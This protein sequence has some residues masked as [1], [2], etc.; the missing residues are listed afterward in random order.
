MPPLILHHVPDEELYTGDDGL[1]RPYAMLFGGGNDGNNSSVRSRRLVPETGS[2]GKSTRRSRS[3]T[4]TPAAKKEDPT[5]AAAD[6]IFTQFLA[7]KSCENSDSTQ[8][9]SNLNSV[10]QLNLSSAS[11][12]QGDGSTVISRSKKHRDKEPTEVILRGFKS[13][14]QYAAIREYERIAGRICEDYPRDPPVDQRRYKADLRDP[15]SL[16]KKPLT[17]EEKMKS[18]KFAGGEHWIKVTFECAEFAETAIECSP[19]K[20]LGHWVFAEIYRGVPPN[21]DEMYPVDN[22]KATDPNKYEMSLRLGAAPGL[23][24]LS[25]NL[26]K[27]LIEPSKNYTAIEL[28]DEDISSPPVPQML[29]LSAG[30]STA[31]EGYP[32]VKKVSPPAGEFCQR[33]PSARRMTL[34][35]AEEALLPQSS[36]FQRF[37]SNLP[38]I[39][40]ISKD[41][42]GGSLPRTEQGD[43][44]YKNASIYWRLMWLI[45]RC[46]GIVLLGDSKED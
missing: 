41:I 19:Q 14:Q 25:N 31:K 10:S 40:W 2:F 13:S 20:I 6:A 22:S 35:P 18:N 16:R 17:I 5:L 46:T 9:T 42:I 37:L 11:C 34:L 4:G 24:V 26:H 43:F 27:S 30:S 33:I 21:L 8:R 29:N 38:F 32:T 39:G 28:E 1:Q 3:R 45:E 7:Q 15:A 23:D 44:D 12:G 36:P